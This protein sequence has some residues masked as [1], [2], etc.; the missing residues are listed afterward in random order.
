MARW[1]QNGRETVAI[2]VNDRGLQYADG[3]FETIAIRNGEPR[4]WSLHIERLELGCRRLGIDVPDALFLASQVADATMTAGYV[5][6]DALL[7]IIVTRGE[8]ERGYAPRD[9]SL[10]TV[11]LG[12]FARPLYPQRH[13]V[14]GLSHPTREPATDSRHQIAFAH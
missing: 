1:F 6:D 14:S 10:P 11:L 8:G 12:L 13:Y 2:S 5:D 7:K 3:V 9:D 4:L